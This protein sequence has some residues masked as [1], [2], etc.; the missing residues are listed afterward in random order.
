MFICTCIISRWIHASDLELY[1][2]FS[3]EIE[4]W[5][6]R[7]KKNDVLFQLRVNNICNKNFAVDKPVNHARFIFLTTK[8]PGHMLANYSLMRVVHI[9]RN[10]RGG[11]GSQMITYDYGGRGVSRR[12]VVKPLQ[13]VAGGKFEIWILS[14]D[15]MFCHVTCHVTYHVTSW[16]TNSNSMLFV[17]IEFDTKMLWS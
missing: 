1:S 10:Q 14:Y 15:Q 2:L 12:E 9:K 8:P 16:R 6:L 11:G 7:F 13:K 17:T 5:I 3:S 4:I